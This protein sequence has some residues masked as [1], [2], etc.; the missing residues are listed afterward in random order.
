MVFFFS[1][2]PTTFKSYV[3]LGTVTIRI[4][5]CYTQS[6]WSTIDVIVTK[7]LLDGYRSLINSSHCWTYNY[8]VINRHS[9]SPNLFST[10][11]I[12]FHYNYLRSSGGIFSGVSGDKMSP[13]SSLSSSKLRD[14][15]A[16]WITLK[17]SKT[18]QNEF[19]VHS[20]M[21]F[22]S[23]TRLVAGL[24]LVWHMWTKKSHLEMW[25]EWHCRSASTQEQRS[26]AWPCH[27]RR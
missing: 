27:K 25:W 3:L 8:K 4:I 24:Q 9:R 17:M 2:K 12:N 14:P 26:V 20:D 15:R 22:N 1:Y 6:T 21:R 23:L 11:C 7:Y 19:P 10:I 5:C 18:W 16:K 13:F